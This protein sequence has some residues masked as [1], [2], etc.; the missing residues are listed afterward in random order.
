ML[1][2]VS[3]NAYTSNA[4]SLSTSKKI[5]FCATNEST[6]KAARLIYNNLGQLV[7]KAITSP[8]DFSSGNNK[9]AFID[10]FVENTIIPILQGKYPHTAES[11]TDSKLSIDELAEALREAKGYFN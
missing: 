9:N 7:D 10:A 3:F 4:N 6:K 2:N 5:N 11:F 8:K 1:S